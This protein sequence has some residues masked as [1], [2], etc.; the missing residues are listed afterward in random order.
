MITGK[1][2]IRFLPFAVQQYMQPD[3]T[4]NSIDTKTKL[5]YSYSCVFQGQPAP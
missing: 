3:I 2:D 4:L 1:T 5:L